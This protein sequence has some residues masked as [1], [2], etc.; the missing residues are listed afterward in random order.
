MLTN[1]LNSVRPLTP[2][3]QIIGIIFHQGSIYQMLFEVLLAA[4]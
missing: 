3:D 4:S 1:A 2:T